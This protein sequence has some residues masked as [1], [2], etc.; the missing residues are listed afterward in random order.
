[1]NL[2]HSIS[3][4]RKL[5]PFLSYFSQKATKHNI[6]IEIR[7]NKYLYFDGGRCAGYC[8][9]PN[10][11]VARN[12]P[13]F[14][15]TLTHE[16]CHCDQF[17]EK[18]PLWEN[19]DDSIWNDLIL[20]RVDVGS[21]KSVLDTILLERDC[22]LRSI[23]YGR[24]FNLFGVKEYARRTNCYLFYYHYVFLKG[25]WVNSN[26]IYKPKILERMPDKVVSIDRLSIIDMKLM[27]LY[28]ENI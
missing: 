9:G 2:H 7:P 14:I 4:P 22:E 8:D 26:T 12:I 18:I 6:N 1:M 20:R 3:I 28:D 17:I 5:K 15:E 27:E 24:E 16:C 21:W 25:R 13:L 23:E 10:V 11:V 19:C